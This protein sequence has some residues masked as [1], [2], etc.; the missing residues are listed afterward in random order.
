MMTK[1]NSPPKLDIDMSNAKTDADFIKP[2]PTSAFSIGECSSEDELSKISFSAYPKIVVSSSSS[3]SSS[4]STNVKVIAKV[5][6]K[7][8]N[9]NINPTTSSPS[10]NKHIVSTSEPSASAKKNIPANSDDK[11]KEAG[12]VY[13]F[14]PDGTAIPIL[15][16]PHSRQ[17][18]DHQRWDRCK[19]T[20]SVI[21]LTTGCI[22]ITNDGRILF[23]SSSKK[24]EWILPKGGWETDEAAEES[25][26]RETYEEAGV[27]GTLGEKLMDITFETRKEKKR[28]LE[29]LKQ[30]PTSPRYVITG[31]VATAVNM[32]S[33][34]SSNDEQKNPAQKEGT[35]DVSLQSP[36]DIDINIVP[37]LPQAKTLDRCTQSTLSSST[38][39][40]KGEQVKGN[41]IEASSTPSTHALV[42]T[43]F[44]PLYISEVLKEWPESGRS[45]KILD[46]DE[47]I[48]TVKREELKEV[49]TALKRRGLHKI[50]DKHDHDHHHDLKVQEIEGGQ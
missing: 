15:R 50:S 16:T 40:N 27:L 22:P 6:V 13:S 11:D 34:L 48:A 18:R 23:C 1:I 10:Q 29:S 19:T 14:L 35:N 45:R 28:R 12:P 32:N 31:G 7:A 38:I 26:V 5:N 36:P 30:N 43:S 44:F 24:K 41:K 2:K 33:N 37:N 25:A 4:S 49:L 8:N 46:I 21:R 17:G 3:S 42:R 39:D 20:N 47:A 9:N